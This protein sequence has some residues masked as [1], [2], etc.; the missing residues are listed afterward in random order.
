[1]GWKLFNFKCPEG[2]EFE[3]MVSTEDKTAVCPSCNQTAEK[4]VQ[5]AAGY[6]INGMNTGSTRPRYSGSWKRSK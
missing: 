2:H 1:M 5:A 4:S 3:A 6:Q